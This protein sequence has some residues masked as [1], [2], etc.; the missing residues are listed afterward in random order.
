MTPEYAVGLLGLFVSVCA[1]AAL[2]WALRRRQ[3]R[4]DD[5]TMYEAIADDEPDFSAVAPSVPVKVWSRRVFA[6]A[7]VALFGVIAWMIVQTVRV[8]SH[9]PTDPALTHRV[10]TA[11]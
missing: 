10:R 11:E 7:F 2:I 8:A 9:G 1:I 5:L 4:T 6:L 3:L